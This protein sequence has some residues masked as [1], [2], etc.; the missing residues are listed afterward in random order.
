MWLNSNE[1]HVNEIPIWRR[2]I[3]EI[4]Y[5]FEKEMPDGFMDIQVHLLIHLVDD[6]EIVGVISTR[7]IFFVEIFF[8]LLKGFVRQK[9]R[10]EGSICEGY[11][12]QKSFFYV[13]E[14]LSQIHDSAPTIWL[15][16]DKDNDKL[17][18]DVLEKNER[19][20]ALYKG[21]NYILDNS[22]LY[23]YYVYAILI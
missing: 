22:N 4:V 9:S 13:S 12:V 1:I 16:V 8:K 6:I 11:I 14:F 23:M 3:M 10:L 18:E 15:Q 21:T 19:S 2:E 7:K 20:Y 5:K 17:E